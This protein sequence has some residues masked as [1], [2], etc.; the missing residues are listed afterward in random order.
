MATALADRSGRGGGRRGSGERRDRLA[1]ASGLSSFFRALSGS[2]GT[3]IVVTLWDQCTRM[4]AVCLAENFTPNGVAS[5]AYL[6]DRAPFFSA[7]DAAYAQVQN[8]I[9]SQAAMLATSEVFWGIALLFVMPIGLIWLARPP[10]GVV[11]GS[12]GGH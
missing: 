7:P 6:D 9:Q 1:A 12:R 2:M 4:H 8:L 10:F 11:G 3:A 5:R